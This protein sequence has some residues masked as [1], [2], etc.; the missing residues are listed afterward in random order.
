MEGL[1]NLP[2][3]H[4]APNQLCDIENNALI[5]RSDKDIDINIVG[6]QDLP[7]QPVDHT[8]DI[9]SPV[10]PFMGTLPFTGFTVQMFPHSRRS[11][12]FEY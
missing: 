11:P 7:I 6:R 2:F 8:F 9:H 4:T 10:S 1:H 12:V 3:A 5:H